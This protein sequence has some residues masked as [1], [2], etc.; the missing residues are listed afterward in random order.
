M[1]KIIHEE[2]KLSFFEKYLT[3]LIFLAMG[4]GVF[5]GYFFPRVVEVWNKFHVGTTNVPIAI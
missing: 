5:S 1:E 2:R 4:L 3:L